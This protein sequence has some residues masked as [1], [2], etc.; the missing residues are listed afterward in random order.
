MGNLYPHNPGKAHK[1]VSH[2]KDAASR[3]DKDP[4]VWEMLGELLA[5]T[6][7]S[8]HATPFCGLLIRNDNLLALWPRQLSDCPITFSISTLPSVTA[9]II[10]CCS[11][12][13]SDPHFQRVVKGAARC[14]SM[15]LC[16]PWHGAVR[17]TALF[18]VCLRLS[19]VHVDL[20]SRRIVPCCM[21]HQRS[22]YTPGIAPAN[23]ADQPQLGLQWQQHT[24]QACQ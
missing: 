16:V 24:F 20:C 21:L 17:W 6:D 3:S 5:A 7:P 2:F 14:S 10:L 12:I 13:S 23:A 8:G 4:E 9:S 11:T 15:V 22:M 19:I 1:A 18:S